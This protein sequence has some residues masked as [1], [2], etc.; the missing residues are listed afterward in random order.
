M[1]CRLL[2][3]ISKYFLFSTFFP[4]KKKISLSRPRPIPIMLVDMHANMHQAYVKVRL[5]IKVGDTNWWWAKSSWS[6]VSADCDGSSLHFFTS[7]SLFGSHLLNP[8]L[9]LFCPLSVISI[10]LSHPLPDK[11][12]GRHRTFKLCYM[13]GTR[14]RGG[15][16]PV[17]KMTPEPSAASPLRLPIYYCLSFGPTRLDVTDSCLFSPG[18]KPLLAG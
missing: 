7:F 9:S 13:K 16:G 8:L 6:V 11:Y 18:L 12:A 15:G 5:K 14:P 17:K 4:L 1:S 2:L 3:K 10:P